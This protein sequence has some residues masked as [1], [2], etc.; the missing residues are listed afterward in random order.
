M[1]SKRDSK[2]SD[3]YE[4]KTQL[5]HIL[6][7]PAMYIGSVESVEEDIYIFN[8]SVDEEG[9]KVDK[10]K[11]KKILMNHGLSRIY[12]EILLNSFDQTV[13][14]GT[15]TKTIKININKEKNSITILNDG[16][17]IPVIMK[18]EYKLYV[19]EMV[20]GHL[21]TSSNY[22][23]DEKRIVGGQNGMGSKLTNIFSKEFILETIDDVRK[24][25]FKMSWK[26]NFQKD[27]EAEIKSCRKK[28][29]TSITFIPDLERF[30]LTELSDD[31]IN[32]FKKRT[33]DICANTNKNVSI[34]YND[35]KIPIKK[36]QDYIKLYLS[37]DSDNK[38]IVDEDNNERWSVG[39][40]LNDGF[41]AVSFV[42][43]ICTNL[44]GTH[45]DHV[46]NIITKEFMKKLE[47]KKVEVKSSYIKDNMLIFVKSFIEN[48]EFNSQTKEILKTKSSSFGSKFEM[49]DKFSKGIMKIG[50]LE[51]V[52]NFSKFKEEQ[53]MNKNNGSKK[54]KVKIPNLDDAN[55]AGTTK[56][57]DCKLFLTEGLSA[58][59]YA[60]NG[61]S[62]IGRD[63]FGVFPLK[64]KL[65]NVRDQSPTKINAN[66]EITNLKEIIGLKHGYKYTSLSELR[67]G[68]I[69]IL[70]DQDLDGFHI[71]G[72]ITNMI[73][74]FWP[75][76]I[77]LGFICSFSTPIVKVSKGNQIKEFFTITEF[78]NWKENI[79][80]SGWNIKYFKGLGTSTSKEAKDSFNEFY[81]KLITYIQTKK[82]DEDINLGFNKKL[83]NKRKEWLLNYNKQEIITQQE[84][85]IPISD[86]IHKELKHFSYYDIHRSIPS[87]IDGLK[88]TQRKILYTGF[89]YIPNSTKEIKVAQFGAKVSEKTSYHHG[90][91]SIFDTVIN[92]AQD[93][94]GSNNMNLLL[95][96]GNFGSRNHGG[97]DHASERYIFTNI[98]PVAYKLYKK[99]DE[100]IINYLVEEG[101]TIE[102]SWYLPVLPNILI[103]GSIGIGTGF[104]TNISQHKVEDISN[105]MLAK[106]NNTKIPKIKPYYRF[107]KG[108]IIPEKGKENKNKYKV[109]GIYEF[110]DSDSSMVITELPVGSW[111][112]KYKE[113]IESLVIEKTTDKKKI[114]EQCI[115]DFDDTYTSTVSVYF[116]LYFDKK[117][118]TE[119]KGKTKDFIY[120]KFKLVSNISENNM[121][122]FDKDNQIKKYDDIYE[123]LDYFYTFRLEYYQK[124]KDYILKILELEMNI[125]KNKVR[126]IKNVNNNTLI[127]IK[128]SDEKLI[129]QLDDQK[130]DKFKNSNDD[131]NYDY[132]INMKIRTLTNENAN[133]LTAEF[134]VKEEECKILKGTDIKDL[135]KTDIKELIEEYKKHNK[136]LEKEIEELKFENKGNTKKKR[137]SKK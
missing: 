12:E 38:I 71:R 96:N 77:D 61:L 100:G 26:N 48:P 74:V 16:N 86:M 108:E 117:Y 123:I 68:G 24:K 44:N 110:N 52:L 87:L 85:E 132:L 35:E 127:I 54:K 111:T 94:I 60:L 41:E 42:N 5:E 137:N 125:L 9:N 126:F 115:K 53:S 17:G 30:G 84:K 49:S 76:L 136:I 69:I 124:R 32:L 50:I 29:F 90:E 72:L 106:L 120:K 105:Y 73:H 67:Y 114:K 22:N 14:E 51:N 93:Y 64:G 91:K 7:R 46:S 66:D 88:P 101:Q 83:A 133:K 55:F 82:T 23:K 34:Y 58:S 1:T 99:Q 70:T 122:L 31:I 21:F 4:K 3:K 80:I 40:V 63:Y 104:S 20:F 25:S 8:S 95:P 33:Y 2:I 10:I 128:V 116:K 131:F 28:G 112:K 39:L 103:N 27:G 134:K 109:Y 18:E 62:K 59:N 79:N 19:P 98:H 43:G 13:R 78:E 36:F 118:Y 56:S 45:V 102:P 135:W 121:Y 97:A 37:N 113:F 107:F 47:K 75:E 130:F 65:L 15:G 119:L 92:M 89:K 6:D 57:Q 81:K 11:K 129:K